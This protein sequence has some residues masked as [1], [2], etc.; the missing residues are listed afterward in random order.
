MKVSYIKLD[1]TIFPPKLTIAVHGAPHRRQEPQVLQVYR[2]TIVAA[3][4]KKDISIPIDHIIDLDILFVDPTTPDLDNLI[5]AFY[6]SVDEKALNG[7]SLMT[8]DGL[9]QAVTMK[10]FY[11]NGPTKYENRI[12]Y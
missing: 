8:D 2:D 4:L 12:P 1:E 11:P 10:K 9:I 3:A 7:P 5:T 6:R